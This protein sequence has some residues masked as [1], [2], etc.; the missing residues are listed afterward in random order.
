VP[1]GE[2]MPAPPASPS[3]EAPPDAVEDS[4]IFQP[5]FGADG[6]MPAIVTDHR[7]GMVLMLAWMNAEAVALTVQS[8]FAHFWTRSRR[9]IWKKGEESGNVLRV[10]DI[11]TDCDQDTLLL[12]VDVQGAGVACHTGR[13]SCFYR[14]VVTGRPLREPLA[15]APSDDFER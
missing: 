1:E 12:R 8:G 10:V 3:T 13:R 14:K 9:R 7:D 2:I 4:L 15:L 5:R 11:R 6:L